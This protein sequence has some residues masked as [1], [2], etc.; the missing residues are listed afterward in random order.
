MKYRAKL[1]QS[2]EK[3]NSEQLIRNKFI[4]QYKLSKQIEPY[5]SG[6]LF[7]LL[8]TD[9]DPLDEYRVSFGFSVDIPKTNLI[10]IFYRYK[11]EDITKSNPDEIN[12]FGISYKFKL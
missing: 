11:K 10:K 1:Q 12:V 5:I 7:H 3:E 8:K 2:Y 6:E 9:S 4:L